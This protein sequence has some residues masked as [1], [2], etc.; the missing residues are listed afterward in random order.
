M[1]C[2]EF[3]LTSK[4]KI[5]HDFLRYGENGRNVIEEKPV[6][7]TYIDAV[8]KFEIIFQEHSSDYNFYNSESLV[9]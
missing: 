2:Q 9:N 5:N 7:I 4:F 6:S 8:T 3:L 1:R